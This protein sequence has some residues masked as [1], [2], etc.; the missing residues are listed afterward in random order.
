MT[1]S[2][3]LYRDYIKAAAKLEKVEDRVLRYVIPA[4]L[5]Y[6][7]NGMPEQAQALVDD[8]PEGSPLRAMLETTL[9]ELTK[10]ADNSHASA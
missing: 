1:H 4:M 5:R 7:A 9:E 6:S 2:Q 10:P 8:A 3:E